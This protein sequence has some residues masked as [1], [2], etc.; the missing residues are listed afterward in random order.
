ADLDGGAHARRVY[1]VRRAA[2]KRWAVPLVRAS[3]SPQIGP[4][5]RP[6]LTAG[7]AFATGG[8]PMRPVPLPAAARR[9]RPLA[10]ALLLALLAAAA[11]VQ[12]QQSV[13]RAYTADIERFT[14]EPFFLTPLVD[15]LPAS[16]T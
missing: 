3:P 10:P 4:T 9:V 14:T 13:D 11:Q 12:A 1:S 16:S 15:H 5:L 8:F 6:T 2:G 7:P